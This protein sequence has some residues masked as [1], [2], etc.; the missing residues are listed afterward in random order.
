MVME[1]R[2]QDTDRRVSVI[3]SVRMHKLNADPRRMD[4]RLRVGYEETPFLHL[5][6]RSSEDFDMGLAS[7]SRSE[8]KHSRVAYC[9]R[10]LCITLQNARKPKP[11]KMTILGEVCEHKQSN[12]MPRMAYLGGLSR[13]H[14][15]RERCMVVL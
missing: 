15:C 7:A 14:G 9:S 12:T 13:Q 8:V 5:E 11:G 10:S 1:C 4:G 3:D 2:I 6:E